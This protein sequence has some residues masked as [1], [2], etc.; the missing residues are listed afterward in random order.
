MNFLEQLV[1]EWYSYRGYYVRTNVRVGPRERGGFEGELDV[2]AFHPETKE[3]VHV[4]TSMDAVS[5]DK[6]RERYDK[7]FSRGRKYIPQLFPFAHGRPHQ[8]AVFGFPRSM[9][10]DDPLGPRVEVV[11]MPDL[12][13][14]IGSTLSEVRVESGAVPENYPLL[15]AMQFSLDYGGFLVGW[16]E[17]RSR[18]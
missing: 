1:G 16:G 2:V 14:R 5:W 12:I 10:V 11:L 7:K 18:V 3:I 13:H 15:R 6:R 9:S 4:E 17:T 8:M